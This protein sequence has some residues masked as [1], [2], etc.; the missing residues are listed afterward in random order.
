MWKVTRVK[1]SGL[2][3]RGKHRLPNLASDFV[4]AAVS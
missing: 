2:S 4:N 3:S 1:G